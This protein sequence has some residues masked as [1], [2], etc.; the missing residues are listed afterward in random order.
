MPFQRRFEA[1][2]D[3]RNAGAYALHACEPFA[4]PRATFGK[5]DPRREMRIHEY[6]AKRLLADH[7]I[8][9][10]P[11]EP[12]ETVEETLEAVERIGLPVVLKAQILAGGRGKS[13]GIVRADT[14]ETARNAATELLGSPLAT[15]QS[16][17]NGYVVRTLLVEKAESIA[18]EVYVAVTIDR[19]RR[20][21]VVLASPEGGVDIE[22][23]AASRPAALFKEWADPAVG[24]RAF[25]A[26]RL[27]RRL[28]LPSTAIRPATGL[29]LALYRLFC[30]KDCSL[31][32]INPLA[33]TDGGELLAIDAKVTLDDNALFRHPEA[34]DLEDRSGESPLETA[35]YAADLNYVKLDGNVG[36]LVNGAG[37]AM[38]TMDLIDHV[39]AR[40][41]NFLDVG[42]SAT[43]EMIEKGVHILIGDVDV[44]AVLIN[45][46]G[47]ILRCDVLA[48]GVVAA[49]RTLDLRI[50]VIVRLEGTNADAGREIL[51][52]SG[53]SF[54]MARDLGEAARM[55][56]KALRERR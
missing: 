27:A 13:G 34:Q 39:G 24:L 25:Q 40:P 2:S 54:A 33:L 26:Y 48:E 46:F 52:R 38:A 5:E 56:E 9:V 31:I 7:G 6:Q 20:A 4:Y 41:A 18:D 30:A 1:T 47:G 36:C 10:P 43:A 55:V 3:P 17:P 51:A 21:I 35:A 29:I 22:E 11:S 44:E 45:I 23:T 8:P 32:E 14:A 19:S 37:L 28:R 50:P 53:L 15:K 42:G 16:G 49:A 12:T